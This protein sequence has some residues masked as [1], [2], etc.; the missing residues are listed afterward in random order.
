L[1]F[2]EHISPESISHANIPLREG[3]GHD[4]HPP[5]WWDTSS[6]TVK[7][8]TLG[9]LQIWNGHRGCAPKTPKVL[10]VLALL[11][12]RA[13]RTVRTES[14]IQE[15]W[16]DNPPRS[17][18][19]T[20]QTYIYQLRR[21]IDRERL[22]ESGDD[23]LIT[24]APGYILMVRPGQ[25]DLHAFQDLRGEGKTHFA[26]RRF[27]EAS[28]CLRAALK[29]CTDTPLANV[30]LGSQLSAHV[31]DLQEQRRNTLQLVIESEME[32]GLHRELI[33]ELTS[34]TATY[35]LDEWFHQQLMRVLDRSGRRSDALRVYR[36]L[37]R[38][39]DDELGID[40]SPETQKLHG[41]LLQ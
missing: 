9:S 7:F 32:L 22:A 23:M 4:R 25:L 5:L 11:L 33:A 34:M 17:A 27:A 40:P 39:L 26:Q 20:I 3:A 2:T 36:S 15:L 18:L 1:K 8:A 35:A 16:G 41:Q 14:L 13:N 24:R 30:K 31:V 10:Q 29:L 6:E 37:Q 38:T 19:T 28:W 21:L 12:V